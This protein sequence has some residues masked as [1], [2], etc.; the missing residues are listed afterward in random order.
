MPYLILEDIRLARDRDNLLTLFRK[1]G[2]PV[3]PSLVAL[4]PA[5]LDFPARAGVQRLFLLA[6]RG[7]LQVF[8]FELDAVYM[9]N[10]RALARDLLLRGGNYLFVA[11]PGAPPYERLVFVNPRRVGSGTQLTVGI[12]KL[13]VE[14]A[15]PTRHDLDVL[16]GIAA[17]GLDADA[18]YAAQVRAFDVEQV[19]KRFYRAYADLFRAAERRIAEANR[20]LAVFSDAKQLRAFTQRLLS[21]LMFLYFLQRKGWLAGDRRFLTHWYRRVTLDEG[22]YWADF[23]RPLCFDTLNRRRVGDASAWGDIPYLNG[24]LF[25]PVDPDADPRVFLPND[26]FDPHDPDGLLGFLNSYNFTVAEDTPLEQEV[27]LDPEMLGK[28]F[29]NLLEEEERGK[30]GT[31]YTPRAIV[32]YLAR[33]SLRHYLADATGLPVDRIDALFAEGDE[34]GAQ[35]AAP[36]TP[37]AAALIDAALDAVRV[38]DPAVGSGAFL[39][40]MLHELVRVRRACWA[41][42][43]DAGEP[44]IAR[45]KRDFIANSLYGVDIKPEAVEIARL[46]LWLSLVVDQRREEVEP[47]PN[48]DYRLREGD[49][50]LETLDGEPILI[51]LPTGAPV[52]GVPAVGQQLG[53]PLGETA[54]ARA[55]LSELK[56]RYFVAETK[57][58]RD[59]LRRQIE[60]QERALVLAA[61]DEKLA[62]VD[63]QMRALVNQGS[64]VNW[65]GLAGEKRELEAL[66]ARKA[67]LAEAAA[68]ARR[69][70]PLPFFL[71]RLH[72]FEVFRDRGG[73]DIVLANPPYVRQERISD[74]KPALKAAY[75]DVYHGAADLYVYFYARGLDLLR[76]GGALAYISSNKF[77]RAGYGEK[78]RR[79]LGE[80]TT[81]E[82]VIDFGD[83]PVFEATAYPCIVVTR[84]APSPQGHA[85][86]AL[87]VEDMETLERLEEVISLRGGQQPARAFL[88]AD[89]WVLGHSDILSLTQKLGAMG[90]PLE[91]VVQRRFF[92]GIKTGCNEA[93][94]VDEEARSRLILEDPHSSAVIRP[95]LRGRDLKRWQVEWSGLYV[96]YIPWAFPLK[97]YPAIKHI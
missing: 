24:G 39:V 19:T 28:V 60:A 52:E 47:L 97:S 81:V 95:W 15:H 93:S 61:L 4:D 12:R 21:R 56:A 40:G 73:F 74:Q 66:A 55:G 48:L 20:A 96:L 3:E 1:L 41:A 45:W 80:K 13:T 36:L 71:Y 92:Y 10:L 49:S 44:P 77:M 42:R 29:E 78:L 87:T 54:K 72:F 14:P 53:L 50:L 33:A 67:R 11:A 88:Q 23:L 65:K 9:A 34:D 6:E 16:E 59:E 69:G 76:P 58:E 2:Y 64:Q 62:D 38:L 8:L 43:G 46:R 32:H 79:T 86:K 26:L 25:E 85:F 70:E 63:A 94:I 30:S 91:E 31:F 37:D 7:N 75:P 57:A 83:L 84:K 89:R 35:A 18:L 17:D 27:A 22:N 51:D 90:R 68:N 82:A 5:A